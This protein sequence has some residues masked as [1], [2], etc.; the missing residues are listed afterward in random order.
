MVCI[1]SIYK[2]LIFI[3]DSKMNWVFQLKQVF[4]SNNVFQ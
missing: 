4:F 2:L 1:F 3:A